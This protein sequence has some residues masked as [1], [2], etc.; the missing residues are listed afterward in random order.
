MEKYK[1]PND[2]YEKKLVLSLLCFIA[3]L[4][5]VL[6]QEERVQIAFICGQLCWL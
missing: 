6:W 2:Y 4:V 5:D 3:F 1:L